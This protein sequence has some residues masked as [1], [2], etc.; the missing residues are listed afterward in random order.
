MFTIHAKCAA[1]DI[2]FLSVISAI[3]AQLQYDGEINSW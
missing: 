2:W 1:Q 3:V